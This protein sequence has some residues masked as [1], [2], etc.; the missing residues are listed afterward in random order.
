MPLDDRDLYAVLGVASDASRAQIGHAYRRLVRAHHPDF[1][2]EPDSAALVAAAA[3]YSILRDPARRAAYDRSR[4]PARDQRPTPPPTDTAPPPLHARYPRWTSALAPQLV[5]KAEKAGRGDRAREP[6]RPGIQR[7]EGG[8]VRAA[9]SST[10]SVDI[11]HNAT[12]SHVRLSG[13]LDMA[14]AGQLQDVLDGLHRD[15][16]RRVVL[17]LSGLEFLGAAGLS[18]LL[19]ADAQF[20]AV[21]GRVALTQ[22]TA[23][24]RRMLAITGLDT[25]LII[26]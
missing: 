4:C 23:Q 26:E 24:I 2:P 11:N 17:D 13:E 5:P 7:G 10:L 15:G 21:G 8:A 6:S 14:T 9:A 25:Q 3:A 22:P 19:R 20:R 16:R 12:R 1:H 18:V